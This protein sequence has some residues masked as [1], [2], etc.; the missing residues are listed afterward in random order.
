MSAP[1]FQVAGEAEIPSP[2]LVIHLDRV[3]ANLREMLRIAGDPSRL[4]PHVKTHK[5]PELVRRQVELGITK[6]KCATIAEAEMAALNGAEDILLAYQP[7][8]PGARRIVGLAARYPRCR[9]S[10]L[11]DDA[12]AVRGLAA[13]HAASGMTGPLD[14][15]LDL[16][17]GQQRSGIAPGPAAV[18]LAK[19]IGA[20]AGLRFGGLHAYDGHLGITDLAERIQAC[21]AAFA[22]VWELR[23]TLEAAGIAVPRIV[24]GGTPTFPVHARRADVELSPG[25]CVFWDAGYGKKF[26]DLTF[27]PAAV[28]LARVVSKPT[29]RR[30]CLDLGHKAVA[31]EMPAPRV[32]FLDL[33][34]AVAVAH[35]EEHL[36]VE[37]P[38]AGDRA[39]GDRVHGIPWHVCPTVAL[40]Q[41]VWVAEAG[42]ITGRWQVTARARRLEV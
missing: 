41:E 11:A 21:E 10:C 8:G 39:V 20:S 1:W 19:L 25:T 34:D 32:V 31:S 9:F 35:N 23:R 16:D 17:V 2:A 36:V 29:P 3:E 12:G 26:P 38:H 4:R 7:V 18:D 27:L 6:V 40:H 24:A 13:A 42:K 28:L 33:P 30:L 5:L 14:V 37:T 22:P 15:M